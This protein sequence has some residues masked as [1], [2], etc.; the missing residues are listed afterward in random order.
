MNKYSL[1]VPLQVAQPGNGE[2]PIQTEE[3]LPFNQAPLMTPGVIRAWHAGHRPSNIQQ[4][5]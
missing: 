1:Q 5:L 4:A 3:G 2:T